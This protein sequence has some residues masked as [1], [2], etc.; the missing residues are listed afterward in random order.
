MVETTSLG[1]A[2][3]A[4]RAVGVWD[5]RVQDKSDSAVFEPKMEAARRE[6]RFR[7]WNR[8]VER[9]LGWED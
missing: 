5:F 2:I 6:E 3:A 9:S 4:G 7:K 1:A 8:A